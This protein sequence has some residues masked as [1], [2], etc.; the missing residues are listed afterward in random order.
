MQVSCC[1]S[2]GGPAK[3]LVLGVV[4]GVQW[5]PLLRAQWLPF[6]FVLVQRLGFVGGVFFPGS[7]EHAPRS[8]GARTWCLW[9]CLVCFA[10]YLCICGLAWWG[11]HRSR[12]THT[13][14]SGEGRRRAGAPSLLQYR[15][16]CNW[17]SGFL[18]TQFPVYNS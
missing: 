13:P 5:L 17:A 7:R 1:D 14:V 8:G 2:D 10:W 18:N 9:W 6:I 15:G 12:D 16:Y 3:K 4:L 11:R